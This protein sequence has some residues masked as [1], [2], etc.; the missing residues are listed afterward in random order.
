MRLLADLVDHRLQA[1]ILKRIRVRFFQA[2]GDIFHLFQQR[3]RFLRIIGVDRDVKIGQLAGGIKIVRLE[4]DG[5]SERIYS[6]GIL[7]QFQ[8]RQ[9]EAVVSVSVAGVLLEGVPEHDRSLTE[10]A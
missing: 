3:G 6:V 10:L 8:R 2:A 7:T 4:F 5:P 9:R 1:Q